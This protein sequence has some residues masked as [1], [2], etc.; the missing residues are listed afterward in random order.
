MPVGVHIARMK[1]SMGKSGRSVQYAAFELQPV[2]IEDEFEELFLLNAPKEATAFKLDRTEKVVYKQE[3]KG[4]VTYINPNYVAIR[5]DIPTFANLVAG[6]IGDYSLKEDAIKDLLYDL[7]RKQIVTPYLPIIDTTDPMAKNMND[8]QSLRYIHSAMKQFPKYKVP[9]LIVDPHEGEFY[10]LISYF[11]TNPYEVVRS[12]LDH[13]CYNATRRRKTIMGIPSQKH[14]LHYE[15]I[16][17]KPVP[18]KKLVL[19]RSSNIN[20]QTLSLLTEFCDSTVLETTTTDKYY[21]NDDIEE[22]FAM[23][24]LK[25]YNPSADHNTLRGYT[26]AGIWRQLYGENGFYRTNSANLHS[27]PYPDLFLQAAVAEA[28]QTERRKIVMQPPVANL[29]KRKDV[30]EAEVEAKRQ[31]VMAMSLQ[32][33]PTSISLDPSELN[34]I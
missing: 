11:E 1:N 13:I 24:Y 31:H 32:S 3:Y 9:V 15:P 33:N 8:I 6:Q 34:F 22:D 4:N 30:M 21:F 12:M 2:K 19:A 23:D 20:E 14:C 18:E 26:P 16:E 7:R 25:R 27:Q 17:I 29:G 10:I 5:N 28:K